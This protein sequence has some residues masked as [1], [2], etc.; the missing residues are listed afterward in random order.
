[1]TSRLQIHSS[2]REDTAT[3]TCI[4]TNVFGQSSRTVYL[5]VQVSNVLSA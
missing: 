3:F 2:R 5:L 1:M 4:A